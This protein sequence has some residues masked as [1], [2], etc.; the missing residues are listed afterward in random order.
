MRRET[1]CAIGTCW[2]AIW[3]GLATCALGQE[4][5][6]Y[7]TGFESEQ[8]YDVE[9]TLI[10]QDGWLGEGN[11]GNG[12]MDNYFEDMGQQAYIGYWPPEEAA[13]P[14]TSLWRPVDGIG[15]E[16]TRITVTMLMMIVD[17]TNDRRDDFRWTLYNDNV[18]R[19]MTLDFDNETRNI[20]YALDDDVFLPTEYGFEHEAVYELKFVMDFASN[21]WTVSVGEEVLVDSKK[22]TTTGAALTFGDLGPSWIIR[23]P[24]AP[25]DNYM[26]FDEYRIT[27][28]IRD[29]IP[30]T[31]P[32]LEWAGS[33]INGRA[34]LRLG[35]NATT[36]YT[37]EASDDLKNWTSIETTKLEDTWKEVLIDTRGHTQRFYRA[38]AVD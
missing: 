2:L 23:N 25:G 34:K 14:F 8:D 17:S 1:K 33:L 12:L 5:T 10:D 16:E 19:L 22:L 37:V 35:G 27:A 29:E 18:R 4:R 24:E 9:F 15:P 32:T 36:N 11:G 31:P 21:S 13:E 6:V 20:N 3:F 26:V 28:E 7:Y 30:E 38:R